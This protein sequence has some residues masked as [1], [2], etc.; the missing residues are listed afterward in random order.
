LITNLAFVM[1]ITITITTPHTASIQ[2]IPTCEPV[3]SASPHFTD[4]LH[5]PFF[6]EARASAGGGPS[7]GGSRNRIATVVRRL[8]DRS[9][10][11]YIY[12]YIY[13]CVYIY[14]HVLY[15]TEIHDHDRSTVIRFGTKSSKQ[16][17]NEL[18]RI[19]SYKRVSAC[20]ELSGSRHTEQLG[21][22]PHTLGASPHLVDSLHD[23]AEKKGGGGG[24]GGRRENV[25]RG[26]GAGGE[27]GAG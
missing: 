3:G 24:G 13:M 27:V 10:D 17:G 23:P 1:I 21:A 2:I 9:T 18:R 4:L 7:S 11:I 12:I 19:T 25:G 22:A 15:V 8:V 6:A 5:A 20:M 14:M 16:D 26:G